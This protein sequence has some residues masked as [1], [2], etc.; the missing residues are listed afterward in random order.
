MVEQDKFIEDTHSMYCS[1]SICAKIFDHFEEQ[2]ILTKEVFRTYMREA[3]KESVI[4]M[5]K[6]IQQ[7]M[8]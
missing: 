3:S 7:R 5:V 2:E 1:V 4:E 8:K 6:F